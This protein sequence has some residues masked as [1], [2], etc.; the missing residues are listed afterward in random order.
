[1]I[2]L[3]WTSPNKQPTHKNVD[4]GVQEDHLWFHDYFKLS[5]NIFPRCL[6]SV[7]SKEACTGNMELHNNDIFRAMIFFFLKRIQNSF[8]AEIKQKKTPFN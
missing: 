6:H 3:S 4:A 7:N 2:P 1:M 8:P 5:P